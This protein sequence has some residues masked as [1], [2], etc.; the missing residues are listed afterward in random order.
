VTVESWERRLIYPRPEAERLFLERTPIP[1]RCPACDQESVATYP[2]ATHQGARM[3]T[4]CQ[5]CFHT[6]SLE[7]PGPDDAWPPFRSVSYAWVASP[8]ER[9]SRDVHDGRHP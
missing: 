4:R 2:V 8:A 3:L 9:A 1:G 7:R 5:R 6:I